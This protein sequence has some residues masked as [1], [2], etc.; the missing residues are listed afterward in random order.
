MDEETDKY[1]VFVGGVSWQTTEESLREHF[2]KFGTV[3]RVVI[4]KDRQSGAPR[5]FAFVSFTDYSAFNNA[6]QVEHHHIL[7]RTVDVK[8]AIPRGEQFQI[9]LQESR[10]LIRNSRSNGN[11]RNSEQLRTR[12]I[13]VGGL[14]ANLTE[15]E[16]RNYFEQFGRITDVVVM[17]DS[18]TRRPRGFGFITFDSEESVENVMMTSFHELGGKQAEVKRAVP[19]EVTNNGYSGQGGSGRSHNGN[20]QPYVYGPRYDLFPG[21]GHLPQYGALPGYAGFYG[22]PYGVYGLGF[23]A[24]YGGVGYG[25]APFAPTSSWNGPGMSG[26]GGYP[27]AGAANFYSPYPNGGVG[28]RGVVVN[29]VDDAQ[30][31][32]DRKSSS[33]DGGNG[34]LA[35]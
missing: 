7:G 16:F 30:V 35:N 21:H 32:V 13:F 27:Y 15:Q 6:L 18:L 11:G 5:G 19:K 20:L 1:K 34:L 9:E 28:G 12:K 8:R 29:R 3:A 17:H 25:M 2:G 26:V 33:T 22:Y 31:V 10:G 4:A 24:G 23:P 14:S